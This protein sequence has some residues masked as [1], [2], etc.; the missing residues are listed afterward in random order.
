MSFGNSAAYCCRFTG[1][2]GAG[3]AGGGGVTD[4]IAVVGCAAGVGTG[5]GAGIAVGATELNG[6]G[7]CSS[8]D[9]G[10]GLGRMV[11]TTKAP[12]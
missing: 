7:A 1:P 8:V 9:S 12:A 4:A 3:A 6:A 11:S 5:C 2:L 10:R